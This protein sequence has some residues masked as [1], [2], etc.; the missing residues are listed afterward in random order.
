MCWCTPGRPSVSCAENCLPETEA[1]PDIDRELLNAI[2]EEILAAIEMALQLDKLDLSY[3]F[4][5]T[6]FKID[7][8]IE[9]AA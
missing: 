3:S 7:I 1:R 4:S 5:N 2:T 6:L 8:N 9:D